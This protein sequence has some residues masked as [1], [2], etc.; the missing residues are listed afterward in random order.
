MNSADNT[1]ED[2]DD[3]KPIDDRDTQ[4]EYFFD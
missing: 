4:M 2:P 1:K 3:I